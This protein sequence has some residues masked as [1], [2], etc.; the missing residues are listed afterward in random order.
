MYINDVFGHD[1]IVQLVLIILEPPAEDSV[2]DS[3]NFLLHSLLFQHSLKY[4]EYY[5]H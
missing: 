1:Y 3:Q 2:H 5:G 4:M